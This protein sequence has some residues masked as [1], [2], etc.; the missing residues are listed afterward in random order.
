MGEMERFAAE[1]SRVGRQFADLSGVVAEVAAELQF[2]RNFAALGPFAERRNLPMTI[3]SELHR[4]H[5]NPHYRPRPVR[6]LP[7]KRPVPAPVVPQ[8][9]RHLVENPAWRPR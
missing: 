3:G 2:A 8:Q 6:Q 1:L 9:R 7:P 4:P 5:K